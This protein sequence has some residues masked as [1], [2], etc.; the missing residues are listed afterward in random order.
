MEK[1]KVYW[2]G[3]RCPPSYVV[4]GQRLFE[5]AKLYECFKKGDSVAIKIHC[6]EWSNTGYL[7]PS[8]V[9]GIV[10]MVKE[11]GGDP[12]VTDTTT[13]LYGPYVGRTQALHQYQTAARNGFTE[14]TLGCPFVVADGDYGTDDVKVEA[15]GNYLRFTYLA[16]AIANADAL[17]ALSHFKGHDQGVYGGA[18]KNIGIG[19]CSKRGK[20][21]T[22]MN[23]HPEYGMPGYI[24][25]PEKCGGKECPLYGTCHENCPV[26][27]FKIVK[28]K[29]YARWDRESCV[30]CGGCWFRLGCGVIQF[31]PNREIVT[32]AAFADSVAAVIRRLGK[33]H[34]GFINYAIDISPACDCAMFSDSWMLPNL[35]VFA[36][37]DIVAV[38][39]ACLNAADQAEAVRGSK[40]FDEGILGEP[41][42]PGQEKF[43]F[44]AT[45]PRYQEVSQW[46]QVNAAV[47]L[48]IGSTKYELIEAE[49][50]DPQKFVPPRMRE[51]TV[52]YGL[53]KKF[54]LGSPKPDPECYRKTP[55]V[56]LEELTRKP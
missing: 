18:I 49:L 4:K 33:D 19:C 29:P 31:P 37:K 22:H 12:F 50:D 30:G 16:S 6:G 25:N 7:R 11:Y 48:G 15:D 53:R 13:L 44:V 42:L 35:G 10:E 55:K 9:T 45:F 23:T 27:A 17:I 24:F 5:E 46:I 2:F 1:S 56:A 40:V 32:P 43:T 41:W 38:D 3:P 34:V 14:A 21:A 39:M 36:S 20:I 47:K 26:D 54:K 52:G 28:R 8:I 51:H